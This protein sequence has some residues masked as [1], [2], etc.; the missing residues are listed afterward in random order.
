MAQ[1]TKSM[2]ASIIEHADRGERYPLTV[3]ELRQL[4]YM[5]SV[6]D[7]SREAVETEGLNPTDDSAVDCEAVETPS[8]FHHLPIEK[9]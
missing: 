6:S 3:N 8:P 4:A 7:G 5:A 2:I 9:E 1:I